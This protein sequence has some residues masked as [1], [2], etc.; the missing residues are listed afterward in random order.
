MGLTYE[1]SMQTGGWAKVD[2]ADCKSG[3]GVEADLVPEAGSYSRRIDSCITQL[4]AQESSR[5][6]NERKEEMKRIT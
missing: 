2:L 3:L 6:C 1:P 4:K 5:T